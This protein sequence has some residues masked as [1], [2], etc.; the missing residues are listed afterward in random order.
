MASV[1]GEFRD[2]PE[3]MKFIRE[4]YE[5]A[6]GDDAY[7]RG[8]YKEEVLVRLRNYSDKSYLSEQ[9]KELKDD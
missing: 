8:F 4:V 5:I 9:Y 7:N 2:A 1:H 6:F 3:M